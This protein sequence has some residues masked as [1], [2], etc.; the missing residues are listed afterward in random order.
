MAGIFMYHLLLTSITL[1]ETHPQLHVAA[2]ALAICSRSY[3][4]R[5]NLHAVRDIHTAAASLRWAGALALHGLP[6][7][8]PVPGYEVQ[9]VQRFPPETELVC[10]RRNRLA[11]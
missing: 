10:Y 2:G 6:T 5:T 4:A 8:L 1:R 9:S 7:P 3:W 11:C